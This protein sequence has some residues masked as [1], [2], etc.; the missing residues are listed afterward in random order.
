MMEGANSSGG[1]GD[2]TRM[3]EVPKQ[4]LTLHADRSSQE[5]VVLAA[6]GNFGS[7]QMAKAPGISV[8]LFTRPR[9]LNLD[10]FGHNCQFCR[11]WLPDY[12]TI[13]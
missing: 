12:R 10:P 1:R 2:E 7:C 6:E 4:Y 13:G 9:K 8:S 5:W 3:I 11:R